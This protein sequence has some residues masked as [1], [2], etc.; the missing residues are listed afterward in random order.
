MWWVVYLYFEIYIIGL[1]NLTIG[2][3]KSKIHG[4]IISI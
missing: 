4:I 2:I 3:Y 1:K